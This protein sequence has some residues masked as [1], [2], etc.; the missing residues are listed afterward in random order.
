MPFKFRLDFKSLHVLGLLGLG[1]NPESGPLK[2]PELITIVI[3]TC[4]ALKTNCCDQL[5]FSGFT[6]P[7]GFGCILIVW[8][9]AVSI[10][11]IFQLMS[12]LE[13]YW[14]I[15]LSY[16]ESKRYI[17]NFTT[18]RSLFFLTWD[19]WSKVPWKHRGGLLV[20]DKEIQLFWGDI[21]D[22]R[23]CRKDFTGLI[24]P[25]V[26]LSMEVLRHRILKNYQHF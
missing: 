11:V 18:V 4:F 8:Q 15:S 3:W 7:I 22:R 13:L 25:S 2:S 9:Y 1:P 26:C 24:T 20:R 14:F 6:V 12:I 23:K 16:S 21:S 17:L 10:G 19:Q 5:A